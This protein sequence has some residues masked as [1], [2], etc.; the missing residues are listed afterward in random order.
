MRR[1]ILVSAVVAVL[2]VTASLALAKLGPTVTSHG[3][4]PSDVYTSETDGRCV[5]GAVHPPGAPVL[6]TAITV[7]T[8]SNLLVTFTTN[9]QEVGDKEVATLTLDVL[10]AEG[11]VVDSVGQWNVPGGPGSAWVAGS[12]MWTFADVAPGEYTVRAGVSVARLVG[13]PGAEEKGGLV[14]TDCALAV[15]VTPVA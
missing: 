10:D 1:T 6:P 12:A 14:V 8:E 7:S 13:Q 9:L 15:L 11:Q 4:T 5:R 3:G 2:A